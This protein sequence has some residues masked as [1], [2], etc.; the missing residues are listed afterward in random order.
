MMGRFRLPV[1]LLHFPMCIALAT[2]CRSKGAVG[3]TDASAA[4]T[5]LSFV[6]DDYQGALSRARAEH[7]L[8]FIDAWAPWCHTCLSMKA[9]VF[10]D[11]ALAPLAGAFVWASIDTEKTKS[12]AF[13]RKFPMKNWPTLWVIDPSSEKPVLKWSGSVTAS[14]L[15][16]LLESATQESQGEPATMAAAAA[17]VQGNRAAAEGR[18]DDAIADYTRV[19]TLASPKWPGRARAVDALTYQLQAAKRD[20]DCVATAVREWP[21]LPPGT[22]RVDV[23]VT[24]LGCSESLAKDAPERPALASLAK[25][26]ARL[27]T[28]PKEPVLA[29]DRSSL[30]GALVDFYQSTAHD[31]HDDAQARAVARQWRD[32]LD[33]EAARAPN[34]QARSVFDSHRMLAYEAVGEREKAIP[35]LEASEHDF[36]DDY[37]PPARLAKVYLDLGRLDAALAAVRRAEARIYGPRALRVLSTEADIWLAMKKPKEAKEALLHAVELGEKLELPG[38]YRDLRE[39]LRTK[40]NAL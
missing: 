32:F 29:D 9:F 2:G 18:R 5:G 1:F 22:S 3:S 39:Q 14:E 19:L 24:A 8:L 38:G 31:G 23:A 28:D 34:A 12:E 30:F 6:E 21:A 10:G 26:A 37:N 4:F 33:G 15:V 25:D 36:P 35:M 20:A 40:A 11:A 13:L 27:A 7:K 16:T 17:W